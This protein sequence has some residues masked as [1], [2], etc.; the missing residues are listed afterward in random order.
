[1]AM[2]RAI[3][4]HGHNTNTAMVMSNKGTHKLPTLILISNPPF[5]PHPS[6]PQP[7]P[8]LH[9]L[10]NSSPRVSS[11]RSAGGQGAARCAQWTASCAWRRED[12][13]WTGKSGQ[14]RAADRG[15]LGAVAG[16]VRQPGCG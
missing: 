3:P 14:E 4:D 7:P 13:R 6:L 1:M 2:V 10:P 8:S 16:A 9:R 15:R 12:Q 11:A 5:A